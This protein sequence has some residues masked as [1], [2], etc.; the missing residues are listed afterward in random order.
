ML[1]IVDQALSILRADNKTFNPFP[2][3]FKALG[4]IIIQYTQKYQKT[5]LFESEYDIFVALDG[6]KKRSS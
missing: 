4:A 1:T 6:F 5:L 2:S 3:N